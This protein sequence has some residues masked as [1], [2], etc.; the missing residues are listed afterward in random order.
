MMPAL[1]YR[2]DLAG[3]AVVFSGDVQEFHKPLVE[4]AAACDTFVCDMALPEREV[5]H[6]HLHVKPSDIGK[7]AA[8]SGARQLVLTHF[9]P[10]IEDQIPEAV[11][12]IRE[13]YRG[14]VVLA[15][16]LLRV[17]VPVR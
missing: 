8:E 6:G 12:H 15:H 13:S 2:V 1:A 17:T 5:E 11:A 14:Q 4:L 9:M 10:E 3:T 7:M 16:D